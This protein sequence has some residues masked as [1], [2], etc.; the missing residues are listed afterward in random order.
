MLPS[1]HRPRAVRQ[2]AAIITERARMAESVTEVTRRGDAGSRIVHSA[3]LA[4]PYAL[5]V[6]L[7]LIVERYYRAR[8]S[9]TVPAHG[10]PSKPFP[11]RHQSAW[12]GYPPAHP[13]NR[14]RAVRLGGVR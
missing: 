14:V 2:A 11:A 12:R 1:V 13:G 3:P 6:R 7:T 9:S 4:S 10:R 8:I 5:I